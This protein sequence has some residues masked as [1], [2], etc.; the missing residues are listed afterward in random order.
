MEQN[1][2]D[3]VEASIA[4]LPDPLQP[5]ARDAVERTVAALNQLSVDKVDS[6][7]RVMACSPFVVNA[8]QRDPGLID[9]VQAKDTSP[10]R[11]QQALESVDLS[12]EEAAFMHTLR[13]FR[14][15]EMAHL[16]WRDLAGVA[17]LNEVMQTL[18]ALA[19]GLSSLALQWGNNKLAQVHGKPI[20]RDSGNEIGM[21]VLGLGKLGGGELN[22][23]SDIDLMFVYAEEGE[24]NGGRGISNH[25]YFTKLGRLFIKLLGESTSGGFVFRVDMRLRP[26]GNSGRWN[27]TTRHTAVTGN[28]TP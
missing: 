28:A 12:Q 23:S 11:L 27:I 9:F 1:I 5:V 19:D 14:N 10:N 26:N 22:F 6:A 24:T 2:Q 17:D 3:Q 20:G 16:A 7:T 25:E 21:V 13:Q 15:R 4:K 8:L 18:S